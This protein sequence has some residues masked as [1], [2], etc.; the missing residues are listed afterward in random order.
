MDESL[1]Y[2]FENGKPIITKESIEGYIKSFNTSLIVSY[3]NVLITRISG[4]TRF[5][6]EGIG[7]HG[8]FVLNPHNYDIEVTV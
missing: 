3:I 1:R 5:A 7:R 8:K 6:E 4:A 2:E